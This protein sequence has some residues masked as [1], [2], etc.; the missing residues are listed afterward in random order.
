VIIK[1][2]EY[3]CL[4]QYLESDL[5]LHNDIL[6]IS[7]NNLD[8]TYK[9]FS[10]TKEFISHE[11]QSGFW[12]RFHTSYEGEGEYRFCFDNTYTLVDTKHVFFGLT[13]NN[14]YQ[15]PQFLNLEKYKYLPEKDKLGDD[16]G[17]KIG[18]FKS[19]LEKMFISF[20]EVQRIQDIYKEHESISRQVA[21]VTN[22]V[23][24]VWSMLSLFLMVVSS[25]AQVFFIKCLF[26]SNSRVGKFIRT[27]RF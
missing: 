12:A 5:Y 10:A 7:P 2:G 19:Q 23:V 26:D 11:R 17:L 6:V 1:P 16:L 13:T 27:G 18:Y 9:V 22:A 21:E 24:N 14:E 20:E 8:I 3:F 4:H 25:F 15:D